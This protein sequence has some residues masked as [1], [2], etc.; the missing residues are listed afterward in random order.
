M[1]RRTDSSVGVVTASSYALVWSELHWSWM[2]S[3]A[4]SVVRTSLNCISCA[5]SDRPDVWMW[6]EKGR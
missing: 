4:C 3:S 6:S 5:C 1:A 2:A